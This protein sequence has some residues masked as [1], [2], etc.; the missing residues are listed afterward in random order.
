MSASSQVEE[1]SYPI[2]DNY[3][4]R[5]EDLEIEIHLKNEKLDYLEMELRE[6]QVSMHHSGIYSQEVI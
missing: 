2:I 5:I 1:A 6:Y 4:K 3:I